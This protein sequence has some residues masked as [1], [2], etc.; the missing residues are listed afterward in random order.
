MIVAW[1]DKGWLQWPIEIL[2]EPR[3]VKYRKQ[4]GANPI[5]KDQGYLSYLLGVKKLLWNLT[6]KSA[7]WGPQFKLFR[8]ILEYWAQ[9]NLPSYV[10][11]YN[12]YVF[13]VKK[14]YSSHA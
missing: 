14:K 12:W 13:G 11:I 3:Q 9:N 4:P 10:L 7:L 8:Y 5:E 1:S 6:E 2:F